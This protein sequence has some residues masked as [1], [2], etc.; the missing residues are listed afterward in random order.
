MAS[1]TDDESSMGDMEDIVGRSVPRDG[2]PRSQSPANP[3]S[4]G[5]GGDLAVITENIPITTDLPSDVGYSSNSSAPVSDI[6][7]VLSAI[8]VKRV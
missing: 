2:V 7:F 3:D 6:Y 4:N 8:Y 5:D 1:T